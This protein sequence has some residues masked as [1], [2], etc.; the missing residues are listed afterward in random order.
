MR[1]NGGFS[2]SPETGF[3]LIF[4]VIDCILDAEWERPPLFLF[5]G[6]LPGQGAEWGENRKE[7]L[8]FRRKGQDEFRG[9]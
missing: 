2:G 6:V 4:A 8:E 1:K 5:E 7:D 3:L 9:Y